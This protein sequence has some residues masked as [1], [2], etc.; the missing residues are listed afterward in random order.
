MRR[1]C[2]RVRDFLDIV[3]RLEDRESSSKEIRAEVVGK[4]ARNRLE[5]ASGGD[6]GFSACV[7]CW[8][9]VVLHLSFID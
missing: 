6:S 8:E 1:D 4:V 9:M 7:E 5:W 2:E 3:V